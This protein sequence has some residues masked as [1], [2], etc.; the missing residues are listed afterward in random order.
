[1]NRSM[2]LLLCLTMMFFG[3]FVPVTALAVSE[4]YKPQ[5]VAVGL[6]N[7]YPKIELRYHD[8]KNIYATQTNEIDDNITLIVP[9][10]DIKSEWANHAFE[11]FGSLEDASYKNQRDEDYQDHLIGTKGRLD[12]IEDQY[13]FFEAKQKR[14]HE[15][16]GSANELR[17]ASQAQVDLDPTLLGR[18]PVK[19]RQ[20]S[21]N[22]GF[23]R[24]ISIITLRLEGNLHKYEFDDVP[25]LA[26]GVIEQEWRNRT[27]NEFSARLGYRLDMGYE[28]F[29]RG[30]YN[31]RAYD[32]QFDI[33]GLERSSNGY[34]IRGG[35]KLGYSDVTAWEFFAGWKSQR[36][37]DARL[38]TIS[39]PDVG[40][41]FYWNPSELFDF[42]L[43]LTR[44]IQ[45][46]ILQDAS[47][48]FST[49]YGGEVIYAILEN[50]DIYA[51]AGGNYWDFIGRDRLD[52][53][54][55]GT[56]GADFY[57]IQSSYIGAE[58]ESKTRDSN[59][60]GQ[61][62]TRNKFVIKVGVQL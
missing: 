41:L 53:I 21:A 30:A 6:F 9:S 2:Q 59:Q 35:V 34:S 37:D 28:A 5:G 33:N 42:K 17:G 47:G 38:K 22:L 20:T 11:L 23:A 36:Y 19:F 25:N 12:I 24:E 3:V 51:K 40:G 14:G 44:T 50:I 31:F 13:L 26:G 4:D 1:M 29:L 60:E 49:N 10:L 56:I 39:G 61:N 8:D 46:T 62:Y 27:H 7:I 58:F 18:E 16:R 48:F 15:E 52:N 32:R 43:Y 57:I 45:E 55:R 54:F